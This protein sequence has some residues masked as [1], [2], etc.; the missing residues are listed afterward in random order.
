MSMSVTVESLQRKRAEINDKT[1]SLVQKIQDGELLSTDD[2]SEFNRL[3]QEF[4]QIS[5]QMETL[6][7]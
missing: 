4:E 2:E 7:V 6:K 1:Q 3:Q 5:K